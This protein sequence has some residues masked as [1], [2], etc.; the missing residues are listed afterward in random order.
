MILLQYYHLLHYISILK[1]YFICK[2]FMYFAL[3]GVTVLQH[4]QFRHENRAFVG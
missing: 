2:N 4:L 3:Q 1:P